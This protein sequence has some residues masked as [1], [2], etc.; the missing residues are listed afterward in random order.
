MDHPQQRRRTHKYRQSV[1]YPANGFC[2]GRTETKECVIS[3]RLIL[4]V[5]ATGSS[6]AGSIAVIMVPVLIIVNTGTRTRTQSCVPRRIRTL[7]TSWGK[8]CSLV[9]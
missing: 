5:V 9:R 2:T 4:F 6:Y 3:K 8:M 7:K 1:S